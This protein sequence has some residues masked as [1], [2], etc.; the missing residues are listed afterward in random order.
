ML[1][2]TMRP[3]LIRLMQ[4]EEKESV[5]L[6][7][8]VYRC[9]QPQNLHGVPFIDPCLIIVLRGVKVLSLQ[10]ELACRSGEFILAPAGIELQFM[11]LPEGEYI[12]VVIG[13]CA[14]DLEAIPVS[15]SPDRDGAAIAKVDRTLAEFLNQWI[16]WIDVSPPELWALRRKELAHLL[17]AKGYG[18]LLKSRSGASWRRKVSEILMQE[19]AKDWSLLEISRSLAVSESTLRRRL[20][21]ENAGF[22]DLLESVRLGMGLHLAQTT[23]LPIAHIADQCGYQSQSRFTERFKQRFG[24]TPSELRQTRLEELGEGILT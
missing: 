3:K 24:M 4:R 7:F 1:L 2:E 20:Q 11:N 21:S 18:S 19:P 8:S 15:A 10:P 22:R 23:L 13:F 16:N 17:Y 9:L 6:P 5:M 12:A 14:S